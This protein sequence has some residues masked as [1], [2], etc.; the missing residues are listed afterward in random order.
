LSSALSSDAGCG[1]VPLSMPA[2][3]RGLQVPLSEE[4]HLGQPYLDRDTASWHPRYRT[5]ETDDEPDARQPDGHQRSVDGY[6]PPVAREVELVSSVASYSGIERG[7]WEGGT[8]IR[9]GGAA[10]EGD[11]DD[12]DDDATIRGTAVAAPNE[13]DLQ[14]PPIK[15]GRHAHLSVPD[16][17][18]LCI[19]S[20]EL[21][22]IHSLHSVQNR[23]G[24]DAQRQAT[25]ALP[26][27]GARES[28]RPGCVLSPSG[29]F[30]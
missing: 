17:P 21:T 25:R 16:R 22:V 12:D 1:Y 3:A 29:R 15:T 23:D 30:D 11:V 8:W 6:S 18:M 24:Q 4:P 7:R 5:E 10:D 28:G 20:L 2:P 27:C 13:G 19:F 9:A 14:R 26:R